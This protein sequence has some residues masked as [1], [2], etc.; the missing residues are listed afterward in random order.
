VRTVE[1]EFYPNDVVYV[2]LDQNT[3]RLAKVIQVDIKIYEDDE[4]FVEDINYLVLLLR[5]KN[6]TKVDPDQIFGDVD[7]A[8]DNVRTKFIEPVT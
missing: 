6:T 8:L 5:D 4:Y 7:E 1:Y 2:V 3:V